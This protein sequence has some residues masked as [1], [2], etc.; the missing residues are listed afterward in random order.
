MPYFTDACYTHG[1][2][3][4]M[5]GPQFTPSWDYEESSDSDV[6]WQG[7]WSSDGSLSEDRGDFGGWGKVGEDGYITR[8]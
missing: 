4:R 6:E 2:V 3:A 5:G 1:W 8:V 7:G